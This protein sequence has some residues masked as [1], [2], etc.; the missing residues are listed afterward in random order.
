MVG[1]KGCA[2]VV[3][4]MSYLPR[5]GC[6]AV[7]CVCSVLVVPTLRALDTLAHETFFQSAFLHGRV[8]VGDV[9]TYVP[10]GL[11][12]GPIHYLFGGG[13]VYETNCSLEALVPEFVACLEKKLAS[14]R[15]L[16]TIFAGVPCYL[17]GYGAWCFLPL[18]SVWNSCVVPVVVR[19]CWGWVAALWVVCLVVNCHRPTAFRENG[20]SLPRKRDSV[21]VLP[22]T[23]GYPA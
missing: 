17:R 10:L 9:T 1:T 12:L 6:A 11:L 21:C 19:C 22:S 8:L 5:V 2:C 13:C 4:A 3:T 15:V 16:R 18:F 20:V 7:L 23:S 14:V